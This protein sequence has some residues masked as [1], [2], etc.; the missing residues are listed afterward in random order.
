M[1]YLPPGFRP[2]VLRVWHNVEYLESR[3]KLARRRRGSM[4]Q[5]IRSFLVITAM[6]AVFIVLMQVAG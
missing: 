1:S 3:K 4:G 5:K 6:I 2:R